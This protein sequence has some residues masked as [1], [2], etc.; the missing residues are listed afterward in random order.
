[1]R[2]IIVFLM[3]LLCLLSGCGVHEDTNK[4]TSE[5]DNLDALFDSGTDGNDEGGILFSLD[6]PIETVYTYNGDALA[7]PFTITGASDGSS[8]E[9][10]VLLLVDGIPQP[11]TA[12][13]EDG[14][15]RDADY[16]QVFNLK[17]A[18]SDHFN[19]VF[20]PIT[21][22]TGDTVSV[23]AM[24]ILDP[25]F[26][27][28]GENNPQYGIHHADSAT[29]ARHITF[30]KD[31]PA[32]GYASSSADYSVTELSEDITEQ[33]SAW[34]AMDSLDT[35]ANLSLVTSESNVILADGKTASITIRFYGGPEAN[36]NI[37]LFVNHKPIKLDGADCL[38]VRTEKNKMIEATFQID[39]TGL[40]ELNTIYAIAATSGAD[41]VIEIN[42]PI[43]SSSVLMVNTRRTNDEKN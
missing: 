10:G 14:T 12:L 33:L 32:D 38:S 11:Y 41:D 29:I 31:A 15:Q 5:S 2:K 20:Q 30:A 22:K 16:M 1:M 8:S 40:G 6:D 24:T 42:N 18:Q 37:S 26:I 25:S 43:K 28:K 39:T 27:A 7:L 13:Y 19:M 23:M 34:G 21:G 3:M 17:E 9:I 4:S 36:F 35:T